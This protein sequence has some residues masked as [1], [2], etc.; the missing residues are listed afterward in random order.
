[1]SSVSMVSVPALCAF[2]HEGRSYVLGEIVDVTP[3]D[4][5]RL[6][7][8]GWVSLTKQ[9][10]QTRDLATPTPEPDQPTRRYRRRDMRA[11]SA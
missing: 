5:S 4:A 9:S 2:T 6:A 1:M 8:R 10:Y 3:I 7:R 11:E